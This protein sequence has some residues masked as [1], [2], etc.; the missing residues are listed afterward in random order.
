MHEMLFYRNC[1]SALKMKKSMVAK[2]LSKMY[3]E[4]WFE[5]FKDNKHCEWGQVCLALKEAEERF[6]KINDKMEVKLR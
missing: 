3:T 6:Q 5:H 2:V 4:E 1:I